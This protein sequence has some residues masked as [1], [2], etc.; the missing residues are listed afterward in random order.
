MRIIGGSLK[1]RRFQPPKNFKGR[2]TTDFARESL[3]NIL[4]N[5]YDWDEVQVLDLFSG[6]GALAFEAASRGAQNVIAV[7]LDHRASRM[8]ERNADALDI[9][10]VAVYGMDAFD[11]LNSVG[12]AFD[13][14]VADPPF[15]K[16]FGE[17]LLE[18]IYSKN[19]LNPSG[20][21]ILEHDSHDNF[22]QH[23]QFV[24]EKK[25][26]HVRFSFFTA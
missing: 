22:G 6:T 10:E 3:F 17:K 21:F 18:L 24:K 2:P 16:R 25:Y 12:Q 7:E 14:I 20:T 9:P 1:G 13:I 26:G 19:L 8:I 15:D 11:F 5:Q 4:N 23:P